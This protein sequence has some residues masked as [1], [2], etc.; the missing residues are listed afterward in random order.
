MKA[1]VFHG[2]GDIRLED[3]KEPKMKEPNDAIVALT[4]RRMS[5]KRFLPATFLKLRIAVGHNSR[6]AWLSSPAR[7]CAYHSVL[8]IR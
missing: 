6:T 7:K 3:V 2:I 5:Q 1:V 4:S 8:W